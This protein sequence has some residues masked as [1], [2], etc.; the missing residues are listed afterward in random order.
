VVS[1]TLLLL[2][3]QVKSLMYPLVG[4]T[5]GMDVYKKEKIITLPGIK[6]G[7]LAYNPVTNDPS[8][9]GSTLKNCNK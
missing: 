7:D 8:Y 2:Y 6:A 3:P 4:T 5:A 9:P 1:F